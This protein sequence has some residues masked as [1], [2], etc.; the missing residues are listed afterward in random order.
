MGGSGINLR[1][2]T[3]ASRT[4]PSIEATISLVTEN[5]EHRNAVTQALKV[6]DLGIDGFDIETPEEV[7]EVFKLAD[8]RFVR[9]SA[10]KL[11]RNIRTL[12]TVRWHE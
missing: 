5:P 10:K 6:A 4:A 12:H 8:G 3:I 2:L 7:A 1:S 9:S 11:Q